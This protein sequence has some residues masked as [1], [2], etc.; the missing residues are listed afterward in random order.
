MTRLTGLV[1]FHVV[2]IA[3]RQLKI[4]ILKYSHEIAPPEDLTGKEK[5]KWYEENEPIL[6]NW[7][8][9]GLT[10]KFKYKCKKVGINLIIEK[11]EVRPTE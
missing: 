10:D 8:Y 3:I 4:K 11:K 2:Y 7:T 1:Y 6:R 5:A 9:L